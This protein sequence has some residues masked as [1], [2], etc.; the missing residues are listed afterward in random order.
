VV[1]RARPL[2]VDVKFNDGTQRLRFVTAQPRVIVVRLTAYS[3]ALRPMLPV[4][5]SFEPGNNLK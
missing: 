5:V 1:L 3:D 4:D 2:H